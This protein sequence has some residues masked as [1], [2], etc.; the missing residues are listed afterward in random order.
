MSVARFRLI[1]AGETLFPPRAPLPEWLRVRQWAAR[2]GGAALGSCLTL[3]LD[4][5]SAT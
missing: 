3:V 2:R 4:L 1:P 5:G